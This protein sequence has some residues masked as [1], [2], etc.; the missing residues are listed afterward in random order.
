ML[1][2]I[3]PVTRTTRCLVVGGEMPRATLESLGFYSRRMRVRLSRQDWNTLV[4]EA[5]CEAMDTNEWINHVL[6]T[7]A[8]SLAKREDEAFFAKAHAIIQ[9]P[10]FDV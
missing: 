8:R 5:A 1:W 3:V 6:E 2:Y 9:G 10:E 7:Y 4:Q